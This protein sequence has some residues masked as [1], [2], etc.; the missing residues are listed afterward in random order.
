MGVRQKK[1]AVHDLGVGMFVSDLDRPWH[2]TP[3]PIQGFYIRSEDEI[4]ALVSYCRHV[5]V[6]E[7]ESR[8]KVSVETADSPI[9]SRR[10]RRGG[11]QSLKL[12][13][14]HIRSPRQY[15]KSA[16][17]KREVRQAEKA[18]IEASRALSH[19]MDVLRAGEVPNLEAIRNVA[20]GM[21]DSI[22]RNP[23]ALLWL[24]RVQ[25]HDE[26]AYQHSIN[27]AVWSL[28]FGRHLGLEPAVLERLGMG[29]LLSQVGKILLP[30]R[31][32]ENESM[33]DADDFALYKTY[34][35]GGVE[36]LA[37]QGLPEP[38]LNVVRYH[39]ERHNG[40]GFPNGITGDRIP[41]LAKITGLVD[42]YEE[43]I[44]PRPGRTPLSPAQAV[45]Q[46]Y[47]SRNI[48]FQEDLVERFIQA[49]GVY[50][51]GTLVELNTSQVAVVLSHRPNR[52]LWPKVL[53][54]T[55]GDGQ[56]MKTGKIIDLAN[57]NEGRSLQEALQIRG[58]MP[59]GSTDIDPRHYEVTGASSKWSWQHLVG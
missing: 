33:L 19:V 23:D 4:R 8:G 31:L 35:N 18:L 37:D 45:A 24:T 43:L 11:A 41:L 55:D 32:L 51:T 59:F 48:E 46:L 12:P 7:A 25:H 56:P 29:A 15:E 42:H 26:Y 39:R 3:F 14:I 47:E 36:L 58:C 5:Y 40:S 21:T 27:A 9:F 28:V 52:R 10:S 50:P 38:V 49:T 57:Y 20:R 34:V 17:L 1:V 44:Q 6:D 16:P 2:E 13:P 53:V 54:M 22:L 30:K